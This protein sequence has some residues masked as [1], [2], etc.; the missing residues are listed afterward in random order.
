MLQLPVQIPDG[1]Q[2]C[3]CDADEHGDPEIRFFLH[4]DASVQPRQ[5]FGDTL[6][7]V[8]SWAFYAYATGTKAPD[9]TY[10]L[11][12]QECF[13]SSLQAP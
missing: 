2:K 11:L 3:E 8:L 12:I 13:G 10:Y 5:Y 7:S 9:R 6:N 4:A 1:D